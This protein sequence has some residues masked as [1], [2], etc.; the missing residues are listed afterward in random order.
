M[1]DRLKRAGA[2]AGRGW[3]WTGRSLR[4]VFWHKWVLIGVLAVVIACGGVVAAAFGYDRAQSDMIARGIHVNGINIGG[5]S[6]D[7]AHARLR[8]AY[9]VLEH[10]LVL[11]YHR[12]H[13]LLS[14]HKAEVRVN[15]DQLVD[16]ALAWSH[17][18]FFIS[19]AWRE[20]TGGHVDTRLRPRISYSRDVLLST[21]DELRKR[22]DRPP[23]NAVL[24][25]SYDRVVIK[26]GH[27]GKEVKAAL[28]RWRMKHAL[29]SRHVGRRIKVPVR[30]V[31]PEVTVNT[32]RRQNPAYITI[33]RGNFTLKVF[34]NLKFVKSYSIAVGQAGLETPAGVYHIQDKQVDPWWHV[35][36]SAWAG[37]LA[38]QVIPPGPSDPL[39]A[40]WMGIFNGAGIHGTEETW[41]IGHAVSHGCVR[42]LI[43][44]VIDLYDRV[45]VGTPVYIGN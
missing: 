15:I 33:D 21:V 45:D 11:R 30:W 32:L 10:P 3:A 18:G 35:P 20:L 43:P 31:D 42:M 25:P 2:S 38:G 37:S 26:G 40:R 24:Q 22:I 1:M 17:H 28:L 6:A 13:L 4:T 14:G 23:V 19:R 41:S 27:R 9:K 34:K 36:K 44:D 12:G 5:L 29:V 7:Q 16:Q 39:K 8:R